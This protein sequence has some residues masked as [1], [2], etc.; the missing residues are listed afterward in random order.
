MNPA[1]CYFS[2][3]DKGFFV[4]EDSSL[5]SVLSRRELETFARIGIALHHV[6]VVEGLLRFVMTFV[7]QKGDSVDILKVEEA[8]RKKTLGYFM[9]EL[10]KRAG[11]HPGLDRELVEFLEKRNTLAHS[12]G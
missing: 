10:R 5:S 2:V 11:L 9:A 8:D 1:L 6:Q 12:P 3:P 7:I 4:P